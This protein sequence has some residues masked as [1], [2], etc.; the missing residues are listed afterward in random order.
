M[1]LKNSFAIHAAFVL[2][3]VRQNGGMVESQRIGQ[4][5]GAEHTGGFG[6]VRGNGPPFGCCQKNR[7]DAPCCRE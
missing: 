2:K 7:G 6:I 3:E 1:A 4:G 5:V